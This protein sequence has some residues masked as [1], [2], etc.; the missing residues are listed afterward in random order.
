MIYKFG[1]FQLEPNTGTLS[2]PDGVIPLRR[3]AY[4]LCQLLL[5]H[6]PNLL[7]HDEI[8]D[9]VWGQTVVSANVL[10]QTVSELRQALG[11][12]PRSPRYIET[13]H[14]RGYR[15]VC[16]VEV[17]TA[18]EDSAP[19]APDTRSANHA[20]APQAPAPTRHLAWPRT[21]VLGLLI[22]LIA[23]GIAYE[24]QAREGKIRDEIPAIRNIAQDD[25]FA[26][27]RSARALLEK[28]P[29]DKELTQLMLD[30][31]VPFSLESEPSGASVS[32]GPYEATDNDWVEI[33]NTPISD[34]RLPLTML[35][36]RVAKPG[37]QQIDIAPG[38][39]DISEPFRLKA[40][41]ESLHGMVY[42][43][44]GRV[45]YMGQTR[46][47]S[48]FW[49]QKNE[50]SNR[51][52]LEFVEA[53][54]YDNPK[55]WSKL[56]I[57]DDQ[58]A[59]VDEVIATFTDS[60][61]FPGPSTWANGTFPTGKGD[62]PL[63]GISWYE[64][65]AYAA[66]RG[67]SLP[68][69]FHWWRAA[70]RGGARE[71]QFSSIVS[72]SNFASDGSQPVGSGGLGPYGTRD[73][74]GNVA[75]WCQNASGSSRHFL[76][77]SWLTEAYSFSDPF[78]QPALERKAGFGLRLMIADEANLQDSEVSLQ[79]RMSR[80]AVPVSDDTF[81]LFANQY[82]YDALPLD[83]QTVGVVSSQKG[84]T[85]ER[86]SFNAA[87]GDDRVSLDLF[88]PKNAAPPYQTVVHF[89]GGDALILDS[90]DEAGLLSIE[91]FLRSGRAV[92]Y[93]VY[94]GT[95]E[96]RSRR[97][98]GPMAIRR[99]LAE[100]VQDVSRTLDYL[101]T[102]SDIEE[103]SIAFHGISYGGMR[104]PYVLAVEKRFA[105]AMIL[106][107]GIPPTELPAEITLENY[108]PRVTLPILYITGRDDFNWDYAS[109][110][111]PFFDLLGTP[112]ADKKHVPLK[113]G[114]LP[115]GYSQL[116]REVISWLDDAFGQTIEGGKM[117]PEVGR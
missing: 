7:T 65:A 35:R 40:L 46:E 18:D 93:P 113:G 97:R 15:F 52:Y 2:G 13:L 14:R 69:V 88:I 51:E 41:T 31:T 45:T 21:S 62:H 57:I 82:R 71:A 43:S 112:D 38:K 1:D 115:T 16:P 117:A 48:D 70:G 9:A 111:L 114:H 107:A 49:I 50:V 76:G 11:D 100:Q 20:A 105:T 86:I 5:E 59:S 83:A 68:T 81:Q 33:G 55:Y 72:A 26:A 44:G 61:G 98:P 79:A 80:P 19:P 73:M 90:I 12:E 110:Q 75:E 29:E 101:A 47:L 23:V 84:W 32:V 116:Q 96:R 27:W 85:R 103:D 36:F 3:Q 91:P 95:F 60:T 104:G 22:L 99:Q 109:A 74:A 67:Q 24:R 78:A 53:G 25:V 77:G 89:P 8:M 66:F 4:L 34:L 56:A 63:E 58:N 102:R 94:Q 28:R 54:G 64:A 92:A 17:L 39:L 10:P 37:Y 87:Y 30:L 108:L 106:S 42:V 6:A